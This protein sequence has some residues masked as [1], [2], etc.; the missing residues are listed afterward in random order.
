MIHTYQFKITLE[1]QLNLFARAL[2][3][4]TGIICTCI[5]LHINLTNIGFIAGGLFLFTIDTL[6]TIVIHA[7]YWKINH[8]AL[9]IVDTETEYVSYKSSIQNVKYSFQN[10]AVL[11]YYHSYERNSVHFSFGS[12]RYCKI[13]FRD[14]VELIITCLMITDIENT[15]EQL[16][17]IKAGR[18]SQLLCLVN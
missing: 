10:I 13:I 17:G 15:L 14:G 11:H 5:F 1:Q 4:W 16:F 12:Y 7:Q 3:I 9:L 18:H 8:N 6:P 2:L